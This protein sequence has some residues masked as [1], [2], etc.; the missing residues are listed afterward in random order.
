MKARVP[1]LSK[2]QNKKA[3]AEIERMVDKLLEEKHEQAM[4]R[5]I[6]LACI[7]LNEEFGFGLHRLSKFVKAIGTLSEQAD[8][9]EIFWEH[10][11]R[12]VID[13]LGLPFERDYSDD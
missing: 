13:Q 2:S 11:D 5:F 10:V 8:T 3:K 12:R 4:R 6:K 9:D 1:V 7:V